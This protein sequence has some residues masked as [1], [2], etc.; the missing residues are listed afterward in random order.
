MRTLLLS[1]IITICLSAFGYFLYSYFKNKN[2][3]P[4]YRYGQILDSLY[5]IPVYYNGNIGHVEGRNKTEDGYNIGLKYQCVEFVKRYYYQHYNHKMPD[6]Y[7]NAVDFFDTALR[8]SSYNAKR[9]LIQ[10]NNPSMYKPQ[11]GDLLVYKGHIGNIYGHVSIISN[12]EKNSIEIIQQNPGAFNKARAKFPL[13]TTMGNY[14]IHNERI[15]GW[16]R[17][18]TP[19]L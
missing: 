10:Y 14:Y 6:S 3:N 4:N 2:P 7:G 1:V 19:T 11:I 12:V 13:E 5:G 9:D 18:K 8:D 17:I 16:L 15:L